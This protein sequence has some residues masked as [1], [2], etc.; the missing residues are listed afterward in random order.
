LTCTVS[1]TVQFA[2]L[3]AGAFATSFIP[4]AA[5]QATRSADVASMTGANFTS[6][7]NASAGTVL[8]EFSRP[9]AIANSFVVDIGDNSF[10]ELI[11]I[12]T[13]GVPQMAA[14]VRDNNITQASFVFVSGAGVN[15]LTYRQA[16]AYSAND[17]AAC[18]NG[19]TVQTDTVG[20]LPTATRMGIGSFTLNSQFLNGH[21]RSIR[22]YPTRL[23]DAQLQAI[24]A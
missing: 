9:T 15:G 13:N 7:F 2:Q 16:L 21:I 20:T 11:A 12:Y 5:S 17:F 6:W 14:L 23:T 8:A 1:G 3:E 24:T 10:N 19:G 22:Y 4:T 18:S